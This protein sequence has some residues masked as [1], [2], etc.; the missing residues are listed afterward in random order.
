MTPR[1]LWRLIAIDVS[2]TLE[3]RGAFV[4]YMFGTVAGPTISLLVWLTVSA[5]GARLPYDRGQFVTYYIALSFVSMLTATW[6]AGFLAED[7][8]LGKLSAWLLRP[9]PIV[10]GYIGNNVGEKIVKLPI[11]LPMVAVVAIF[12][13]TD[14]H[15]PTSPRAWTLFALSLPPAAVVS[16][17]LDYL[18]GSLAF[19]VQEI[20]GL[21]RTKWLLAGFLSGQYVPLALFPGW[22]SGF[23]AAQPFRYTVSFPLE[24]L[25][26]EL[27]DAA[28]A[29]GF[30]WQ[31]AYCAGLWLAYRVVW[32]Y[33]LRAY[34]AVGA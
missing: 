11:L 29:R 13:R 31:V 26:G 10:S 30:T 34:A 15:L 21:L 6:L 4:V 27:S 3:Y 7:I 12:F 20:R 25:T 23:L 19:W 2:R 17:L 18:T 1:V 14:L 33:G 32:R 16:F 9:A 5:N 24:L 8:R 28:V 22:A